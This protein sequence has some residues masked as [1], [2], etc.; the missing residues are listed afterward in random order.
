MRT[1][2]ALCGLAAALAAQA[3]AQTVVVQ[4]D[5][6]ALEQRLAAAER[7]VG[8][9]AHIRGGTAAP[10]WLTDR[11]RFLYR[12]TAG[13]VARWGLVDGRTG[14]VQHLFTE[15]EMPP[16]MAQAMAGA[17]LRHAWELVRDADGGFRVSL[18]GGTAVF[19][20]LPARAPGRWIPDA[21][22]PSLSADAGGL[23]GVDARG[24]TVLTRAGEAG[25]R[26]EVPSDCWSAARGAC[27]VFFR[28]ERAVHAM[29]IVDYSHPLEKV[30]TVRYPKAGT[31]IV[32]TSVYIFHPGQRELKRV[33]TDSASYYWFAGWRPHSS[34]FLVLRLER[35]GKQLD[36]LA[37]DETNGRTRIVAHDKSGTSVAGLEFD[38][39]YVNQVRP[40]PD[41]ERFLWMSERDGWRHVYM[42]RFDGTVERQITSGR[43]AVRRVLHVDARRRE[44]LVLAAAD[45]TRPYEPRVYRVGLDG[46]SWRELTPERGVHTAWVNPDGDY[47]VD[48]YSTLTQPPRAMLRRR[49]RSRCATARAGGHHRPGRNRIP[50]ARGGKRDGR[51]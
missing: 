8:Y 46:G 40:L 4:A 5:S 17:S 24:D 9:L 35:T 45:S 10:R 14:A 37:I 47:F 34:E 6:T 3:R 28:D 16:Q 23:V 38:G 51:G 12:F 36:L 22:K 39:E 15:R 48:S 44:L 42:Y 18:P 31:P 11:D 13:A 41:G 1:G 27:A 19:T 25:T 50:P 21:A 29:P 49:K 32:A 2:L 20:T 26:W 30:A 7:T 43:F 33:L